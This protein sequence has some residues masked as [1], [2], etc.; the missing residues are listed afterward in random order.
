MFV[1]S[2]GPQEYS[3]GKPG[4]VQILHKLS[5]PMLIFSW[6]TWMNTHCLIILDHPHVCCSYIS[7][8]LEWTKIGSLKVILMSK[9]TT[10]SILWDAYYFRASMLDEWEVHSYTNNCRST[11]ILYHEIVCFGEVIWLPCPFL[12]RFAFG[13]QVLLTKG[14]W[15][16]H[17]LPWILLF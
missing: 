12:L 13:F 6:P 15:S 9:S 7:N 17:G 2:C 11:I 4:L 5:Y 3:H 10:K 16:A 8:D 14:S 1:R